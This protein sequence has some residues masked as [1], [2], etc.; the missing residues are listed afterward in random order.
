[1]CIVLCSITNE[2]KLV[3]L[4]YSIFG[5]MFF[6]AVYVAAVVNYAVQSEMNIYLL[7]SIKLKVLTRKYESTDEAIKVRC[8]FV[9]CKSVCASVCVCVC[10][11]GCVHNARTR[12]CM[13]AC[14]CVWCISAC[15]CTCV[16]ACMYKDY[17][18]CVKHYPTI[19]IR[20]SWAEL[21]YWY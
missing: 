14:V 20:N 6:D 8:C 19:S 21:S 10:V 16:Y 13:C 2:V 7:Q 12:V 11:G 3:L 5:F 18:C 15:V 4:I 9:W 1:M 17:V